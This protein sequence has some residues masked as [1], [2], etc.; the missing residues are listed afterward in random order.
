V[1][2]RRKRGEGR[3]GRRGGK[4]RMEGGEGEEDQNI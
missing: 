3:G 1:E 2:T 4:M